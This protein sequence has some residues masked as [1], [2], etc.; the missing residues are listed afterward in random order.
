MK[1]LYCQRGKAKLPEAIAALASGLRF[2]V[3]PKTWTMVDVVRHG[4]SHVAYVLDAETTADVKAILTAAQ[5]HSM[6]CVEVAPNKAMERDCAEQLAAV[7]LE[8]IERH[9]EQN[10]AEADTEL[11]IQPPPEVAANIAE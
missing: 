1:Y 8:I 11:N 4:P 9:E 3:K 6:F 5:Q 10:P 7:S 2:D